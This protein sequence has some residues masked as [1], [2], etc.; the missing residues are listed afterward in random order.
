MRDNFSDRQA[1]LYGSL[2]SY[3]LQNL[4][5]EHVEAHS[6]KL[7]LSLFVVCL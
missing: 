4:D 5:I 2:F 6:I 1:I 7:G 3:L